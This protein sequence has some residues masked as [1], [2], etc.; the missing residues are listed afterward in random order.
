MIH[1]DGA[2]EPHGQLNASTHNA[3]T[4][5]AGASPG[6]GFVAG[7]CTTLTGIA[8]AEP[9]TATAWSLRYPWSLLVV[10]RSRVLGKGNHADLLRR[11]PEPT[12]VPID[13]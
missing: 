12:H 9:D 6:T 1:G 3:E 13:W 10:S 8:G 7:R 2:T 4:S 5:K 11:R